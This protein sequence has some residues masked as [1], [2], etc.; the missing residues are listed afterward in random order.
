MLAK[1]G[2]RSYLVAS[3]LTKFSWG[4]MLLDPPRYYMQYVDFGHTTLKYLA[5]ALNSDNFN[6]NCSAKL[7]LCI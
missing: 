7:S 1:N 4:T 5:M 6:M 3:N 2:L